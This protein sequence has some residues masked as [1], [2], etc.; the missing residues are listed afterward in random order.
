MAFRRHLQSHVRG[1][2]GRASV[3]LRSNTAFVVPVVLL[4][5]AA[6]TGWILVGSLSPTVDDRGATTPTAQPHTTATK[7]VP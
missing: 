2:G 6:L 1:A 4:V 3:P 7:P 5:A